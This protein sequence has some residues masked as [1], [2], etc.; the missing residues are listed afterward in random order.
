MK[1]SR[2]P[3]IDFDRVSLGFGGR[4][5]ISDPSLEVRQGE[6]VCIIGPSGCGKTTALRMAG[7]LV[8]PGSGVVRLLGEP[9]TAPRRDVAIVFQD[10]GKA[11]LPWRTAHA[12]V[13]L[14]LEAAGV[15]RGER[16]GRVRSLLGRAV[17]SARCDDCGCRSG[18]GCSRLSC[19]RRFP[20]SWWPS[21]SPR[22]L[23]WWSR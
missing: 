16:D 22:R 18:S 11:L 14:A 15:S 21:A 12:N 13:A 5:V 23:H 3:M 20:E 8:R 1:Q 2:R 19:G 10:Y 9:L 17:R 6:I 4:T 7:G